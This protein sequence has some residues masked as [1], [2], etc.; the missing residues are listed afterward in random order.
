MQAGAFQSG[1]AIQ[2]DHTAVSVDFEQVLD[3]L[4][5]NTRMGL[6]TALYEL[7]K[8][9]EGRGED[10]GVVIDS[11]KTITTHLTPALQVVDRRQVELSRFLDNNAIVV[12]T[13]GNAPIDSLVRENADILA[14]LDS[15]RADVANLVV[16]G[17]QVLSDL[18]TITA[19]SNVTALQQTLQKAP[20]L[21]DRFIHFSNDL[22]FATNSLAPEV[23]PHSGQTQSDIALAIL[24]SEDAFGECSIS[25]QNGSDT[26]HATGV[27][28][29]PCYG[30]DGK[31]YVDPATGHVAHHHVKVLFGLHTDNTVGNG[32]EEAAVLCGPNSG[33]AARGSNPAFTCLENPVQMNPPA[34]FGG[35]PPAAFSPVGATSAGQG[36]PLAT[37]PYI[38]ILD[39]LAGN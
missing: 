29:V 28:I 31:P 38:N 27:R 20:T 34:P 32:E 6:Q 9:S 7:G 8:G 14:K 18:D 15:H 33:N 13:Y 30:K 16:H 26:L 3:E 12:E 22:G 17:N 35:P 36:S 37:V 2:I 10:W 24:R 23:I 5:P 4:D 21:L 19:G 39:L 1:D 25:D 11:L